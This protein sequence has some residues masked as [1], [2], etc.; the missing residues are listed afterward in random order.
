MNILLQFQEKK[1][2]EAEARKRKG[3][4]KPKLIEEHEVTGTSAKANAV[5]AGISDRAL[6]THGWLDH[7]IDWA[8]N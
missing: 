6:N 2:K 4:I 1:K 8:N 5:S 3:V 7:Q